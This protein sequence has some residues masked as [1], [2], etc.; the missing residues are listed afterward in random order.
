MNI[1]ITY[2]QT[3]ETADAISYDV[4]WGSST[5]VGRINVPNDATQPIYFH[6]RSW[7]DVSYGRNIAQ[8]IYEEYKRDIHMRCNKKREILTGKDFVP[9]EPKWL[10]YYDANNKYMGKYRNFKQDGKMCVEL[11]LKKKIQVGTALNEVMQFLKRYPL[12]KLTIAQLIKTPTNIDNSM[13]VE[14]MRTILTQLI[15][16][17]QPKP[18]RNSINCKRIPKKTEIQKQQ[19]TNKS[20]PACVTE[21]KPVFIQLTDSADLQMFVPR[22]YGI[23]KDYYTNVILSFWGQNFTVNPNMKKIAPLIKELEKHRA[24]CIAAQKQQGK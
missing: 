15:P 6:T 24:A 17:K 21:N 23:A 16:V 11:C 14:K 13:T 18:V 2:I 19:N 5:I 9:T 20:V 7:I 1:G 10:K 8:L 22:A 3:E 4:K 12:V